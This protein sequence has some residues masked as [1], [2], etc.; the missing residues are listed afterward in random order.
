[1][2]LKLKMIPVVFRGGP[3]I[4]LFKWSKCSILQLCNNY[5][6][7][8]VPSSPKYS[9]NEKEL[10]PAYVRLHLK[11]EQYFV[12]AGASSNTANVPQQY[13]KKTFGRHFI[14]KDKSPLSSPDCNPLSHY[15]RD[16]VTKRYTRV[17]GNILRV[18]LSR[19]NEF[20]NFGKM[21]M[22]LWH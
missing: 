18:L 17:I 1:M 4:T 2:S 16:A 13:L 8:I 21:P 20:E 10:L 5:C 14:R 3:E 6:P 11:N 19:K 15:F 9:G 22:A 12:R 7:L